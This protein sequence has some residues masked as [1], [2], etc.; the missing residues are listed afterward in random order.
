[1]IPDDVEKSRRPLYHYTTGDRIIGIAS[2]GEIR[3]AFQEVEPPEIPAVWLSTASDWEHS[4][5][6]GLIVDGC[7]RL[8]T[9]AEMIDLCGFLVRIEIDPEQVTLIDSPNLKQVLRIPNDTY[10]LLVAAGHEMGANPLQWRVVTSPV[11]VSAFI[12]VEVT[13]ETHPLR[14]IPASQCDSVP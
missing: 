10:E 12:T 4:A 5:T 2:A 7:R 6:K 9:L 13:T 1:M 14:W 3:P 11:P 8:A